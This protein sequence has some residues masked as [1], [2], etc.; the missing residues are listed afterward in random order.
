MIFFSYRFCNLVNLVIYLNTVFA[1]SAVG[2]HIPETLLNKD[3][4]VIPRDTL[5]LLKIKIDIFLN[6]QVN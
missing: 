5:F 3:C 1:I 2:L 6:K 4:V